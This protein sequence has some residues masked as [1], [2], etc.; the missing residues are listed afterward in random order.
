MVTFEIRHSALLPLLNS[1]EITAVI[2]DVIGIYGLTVMQRTTL[3]SYKGS[4]HYH[5]KSGSQ[6][7]VLEITYWP[8]KTRLWLDIHD[9]RQAEWNVS[10]IGPFA[11]SLA[12]RLQGTAIAIA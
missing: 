12:E 6:R 8:A 5:L 7:G 10:I 9:N 1:D 2:E 11:Q 3:S 4:I